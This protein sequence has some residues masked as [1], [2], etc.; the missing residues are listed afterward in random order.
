MSF[1]RKKIDGTM[2]IIQSAQQF[3]RF[4]AYLLN[5]A[6]YQPFIGN[7]TAHFIVMCCYST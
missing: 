1:K 7:I 6:P 3:T 5:Y 2:E 4:V